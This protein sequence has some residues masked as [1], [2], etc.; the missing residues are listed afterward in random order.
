M[1]LYIAEEMLNVARESGYQEQQLVWISK[2]L[3]LS[4]EDMAGS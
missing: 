4:E 3:D 2:A 1:S